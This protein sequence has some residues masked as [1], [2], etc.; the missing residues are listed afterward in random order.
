MPKACWICEKCR[1]P[2]QEKVDAERC[3]LM[4]LTALDLQ[5]TELEYE[6]GRREPATIVIQFGDDRTALRRYRLWH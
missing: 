4:H 2:Y 3:E 5:I 6:K 1:Q